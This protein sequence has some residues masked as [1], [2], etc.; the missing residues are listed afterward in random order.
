MPG[1]EQGA[2]CLSASVLV[3][4]FLYW[5]YWRPVLTGKFDKA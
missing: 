3:V 4:N 2:L 5:T 1:W